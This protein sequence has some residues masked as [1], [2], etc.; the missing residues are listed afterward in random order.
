MGR[1]RQA[2]VLIGAALL[3]LLGISVAESRSQDQ[4]TQASAG[5]TALLKRKRLQMV[6]DP[7]ALVRVQQIV[8]NI[9]R[10]ADEHAS[11]APEI[12]LVSGRPSAEAMEGR[13]ILVSESMT[14]LLDDDN[15]LAIVLGHE[16]AHLVRGHTYGVQRETDVAAAAEHLSFDQS[17]VPALESAVTQ[18]LE[19]EADRYGLLYAALAGY[20]VSRAP[21]VYDKVLTNLPDVNHPPKEERE[22]NFEA[23]LRGILD[24]VAVFQ[25]G[26]DYALRGQYALAIQAYENLLRDEFRSRDIY[27]NLGYF[28]HLFAF[29]YL[30]PED[31]PSEVCSL[32]LELQSGFEPQG[33]SQ[34]R[35][36]ERG[37]DGSANFRKELSE[38]IEFYQQALRASPDY[39]AARNNLGC[40]YL[41]R[42]D[43]GD[44][45]QA[46]GELERAS[47]LEPSNA[48]VVNNLGVAY[49]RIGQ[50]E[51]AIA[52]FRRALQLNPKFPDSYYNLGT[53]LL[54]VKTPR[55]D[56]EARKCFQAYVDAK[57]GTRP[58][59]YVSQARARLTLA[60]E[61]AANDAASATPTASAVV[62]G[63]PLMPGQLLFQLPPNLHPDRQIKLIP[64]YG[65][66]LLRFPDWQL[67]VQEDVAEQVTV[68][69]DRFRTV[70]DLGVG[71]SINDVRKT[72]GTP[73][74]EQV[75]ANKLV[76]VYLDKGLIFRAQGDRIK[77]WSVFQRH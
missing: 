23:R 62:Q 43:P 75:R 22:K 53:V 52:Q 5:I 29:R 21:Q 2:V 16:I 14:Q 46:V 74:V 6:D 61:V 56:A 7:Q 41:H 51:K 19:A 40:A 4:D 57:Q 50:Q 1:R 30:K 66:E 24:N 35:A 76:L 59:Y 68:D 32:S 77:S 37:P 17:L 55:S 10:V 11:N 49:L 42:Q 9:Y 48:A 72:Y 47:N 34:K 39:A 28:H 70:G 45:Y 71:S 25:V 31:S 8:T 12:A 13:Y 20:D 26:L 58:A 44:V 36:A 69:T 60:T 38:A 27:L 63:L 33:Q 15:E 3:V 64:E 67:I 18:G 65:I 54:S 73:D